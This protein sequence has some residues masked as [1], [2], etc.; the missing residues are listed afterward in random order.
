MS[1]KK[2]YKGKNFPPNTKFPERCYFEGCT[3][4]ATC[5][6]GVGCHFINCKFEKCC[7]KQNNNPPSQVK[8][9]IVENCTLES[10]TLDAKTLGKNNK[11]TG[12]MVTDNSY[13]RD[14]V[15]RGNKD[16]F[17]LCL[18]PK[19]VGCA[20]VSVTSVENKPI[21][22]EPVA[23]CKPTQPNR[24]YG[25]SEVKLPTCQSSEKPSGTT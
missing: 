9:A 8:E 1:Y 21:K 16:D 25:D 15:V 23:K 20:G 17:C 5:T 22:Q 7:P 10:V 6:F 13:K 14:G 2:V 3:F 19:D 24:G 18:F 11:S 12:Y 4:K